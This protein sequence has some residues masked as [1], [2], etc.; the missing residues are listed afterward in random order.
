MLITARDTVRVPPGYPTIPRAFSVVRWGLVMFDN[1]TSSIMLEK[2][3]R[4]S[5]STSCPEV[6]RQMSDE[7]APVRRSDD[8]AVY[9]IVAT[10]LNQVESSTSLCRASLTALEPRALRRLWLALASMWIRLC[11]QGARWSCFVLR[12]LAMSKTT[13]S[14]HAT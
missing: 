10:I 5:Y 12:S 6:S 13:G 3:L 9:F 4:C 7:M 2:V 1:Q 11:I 14:L 8:N